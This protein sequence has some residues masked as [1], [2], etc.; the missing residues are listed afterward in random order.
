MKLLFTIK[1]LDDI[2]G[3]AE[4]VLADVTAGLAED[5]HDVTVL[6]FDSQ[7]GDAFYPLH[8]KIRRIKLGI[9][10]VKSRATFGET[11]RRM[12]ALRHTVQ[13]EHPDAVIAFMHSSFVPAAFALIGTGI[14]VIASEHIVPDYYHDRWFEYRLLLLSRFFVKAFTV[15]SDDVKRR[16]PKALQKKMVPITNPV[17]PAKKIADTIGTKQKTKTILNVGRLTDQKDQ[18][19]L[20]DAFALLSNDFPDWDLRIIGEGDLRKNLE[21]HIKEH[22][23]EQRIALPGATAKIEQEYQ[24]A[25]IF[26]LPSKFESFGL[27]TAE[28][29]AHGLPTIGFASC[30]GT[31]EIIT[32]KDNGLLVDDSNRI[33]NFANGLRHLMENP[34]TRKTMGQKGLERVKSF[35]PDAVISAWEDLITS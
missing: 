7:K 12:I 16:Y 23:L 4:R 18:S 1:A 25:Q 17:Y 10:D 27:V 24:K 22:G 13:T 5:E 35:H 29:M 32:H 30:P 33:Q 6:S 34:D 8:K 2:K 11:I 15:L 19:V 9:G 26:A 3:G 20:I 28:A 31:N 21:Q 14:P